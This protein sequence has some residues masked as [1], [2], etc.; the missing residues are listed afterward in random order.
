MS[1]PTKV[2]VAVFAFLGLAAV[3]LMVLGYPA[4]AFLVVMLGAIFGAIISKGK[5]RG[6]LIVAAIVLLGAA[7]N[8]HQM[9]ARQ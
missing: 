1:K 6:W 8:L 4:E 9:L 7:V 3:V 5:R 2:K